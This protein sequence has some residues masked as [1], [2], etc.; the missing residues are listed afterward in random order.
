LFESQ[1]DI[2]LDKV[3]EAVKVERKKRKISQLKLAEILDFSSPNY[4]AKIETRK[5]GVSY[6]L[7]HLCK[8]AEAF[9]MEVVDLLPVK[10]PSD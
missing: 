10:K 1:P 3:V 9:D 5:H 7:V 8:I 6:N 4:I 2:F